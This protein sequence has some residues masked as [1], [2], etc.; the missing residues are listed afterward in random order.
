MSKRILIADDEPSIVAALNFLLQ[1]NG[2]E[3]HVAQ[4]YL[5]RGAYVGAM[6]RA[7]FTIENYDGSPQIREALDVMAKSYRKLGME[8][9]ATDT[10]RVMRE[11]YAGADDVGTGAAP[12]KKSWWKIW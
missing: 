6:N 4:F 8:D 3:V 12:G 11:N 9:L 10:E 1:S 5:K 7:K 2:Y